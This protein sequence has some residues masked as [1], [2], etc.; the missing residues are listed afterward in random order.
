M[1][2][3]W[4]TMAACSGLVLG[5]P[6]VAAPSA[7]SGDAKAGAAQQP[8]GPSNAKHQH[9]AKNGRAMLGAKLK[10]DGKHAVGK[11]KNRTV[12]AETKGGKVVAMRADDI[13]PKRVRTKTKMAMAAPGVIRAAWTGNIQLAQYDTYYYG[14]CF[15]D[16]YDLD[17]YWYPAEDVYYEDYTWEEYDPYW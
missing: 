5:P 13:A 6:A 7:K 3:L 8:K 12:T 4:V 2:K 10:E 17:C 11:F 9:H 1:S 15:D 14:Y 16:G